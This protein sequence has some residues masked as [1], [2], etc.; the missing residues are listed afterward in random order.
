MGMSGE[1]SLFV[2]AI[3]ARGVSVK[4]SV[5]ITEKTAETPSF[6]RISR[7]PPYRHIR[8]TFVVRERFSISQMF[9]KTAIPV[10]KQRIAGAFKAK[11]SFQPVC[12]SAGISS[13]SSGR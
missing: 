7:R 9:E 5:R 13:S 11:Y 8:R 10:R 6:V 3:T 1:P 2:Y 12:G 4:D